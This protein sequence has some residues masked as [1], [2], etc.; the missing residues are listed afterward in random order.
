[1][2]IFSTHRRKIEPHR[3]YGSPDFKNKIKQ[4][5]NHKR[6][7]PLR[8]GAL[9]FFLSIIGLKSWVSRSLIALVIGSVVYFLFISPYFFITQVEVS[10]NSQIPTDQLVNVIKEKT[11]GRTFFIPQNHYLLFTQNRIAKVLSA[12]FS[13]VKEITKFDRHMPDKVEFQ[14]AERQR[15]FALRSA[16]RLYLVDD[17]GVIVKSIDSE[18]DLLVVLDQTNGEYHEGDRLSSKATGFILSMERSWSS[19]ISTKI[20]EI[21]LT[22]MTGSDAVFATTEGWNVFFDINTPVIIQLN[23]LALIVNKQVSSK[24]RGK[25]AYVDLRVSK[26]AYICY[27]NTPCVE[28]PQDTTLPSNGPEVIGK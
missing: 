28:R 17:E 6:T 16:E 19:K 8:P 18:G 7:F 13:I 9:G 10:G 22:T 26:V 1:M 21:K 23:S 3:R 12:N 25:L 20:T 15:G 5:Q 11:S 27:R 4:A 2:K 14:I 24:D